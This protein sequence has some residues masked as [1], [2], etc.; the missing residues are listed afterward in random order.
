[1]Y[2]ETGQF[3][4]LISNILIAE[5]DRRNEEAEKEKERMIWESFLHS[6]TDLSYGEY[7]KKVIGNEKA[8]MESTTGKRDEDMTDKDVDAL[9]KKLFPNQAKQEAPI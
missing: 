2:I 1:M 5:H 6:N 7:R 4:E 3:D 8:H 9:L